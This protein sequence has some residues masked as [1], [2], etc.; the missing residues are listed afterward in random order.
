M[1]NINITFMTK[2]TKFNDSRSYYKAMPRRVYFEA[3]KGSARRFCWFESEKFWSFL[4][5]HF[6]DHY[7]NNENLIDKRIGLNQEMHSS[8]DL[9][10]DQFET[11]L[12]KFSLNEEEY[13]YFK[14]NDFQFLIFKSSYK[15]SPR[16]MPRHINISGTPEWIDVAIQS[17]PDTQV[18]HK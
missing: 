15:K 1:L 14:Q 18:I 13:E 8:K 17:F 16:Q 4:A 3:D 7:S 5:R 9:T 11:N 2:E 12:R 6:I 10:H